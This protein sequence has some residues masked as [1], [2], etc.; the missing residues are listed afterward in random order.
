MRVKTGFTRKRRH[1]KVLSRTKGMRMTKGR[2]YKVSKEADLHAGQYAYAG[3][4]LRKR[5]LRR[6]W[7]I[8]INAGLTEHDL[9]YSKFIA[10]LKIAK[11]D[12]DR[13]ILADLVLSDPAAFKAIVDK[14][15]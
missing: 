9:S 10:K 15:K 1:N 11:I 2:L 13:K 8:R 5:D 3:R 6:L 4:R 7:I 12:L 14:V